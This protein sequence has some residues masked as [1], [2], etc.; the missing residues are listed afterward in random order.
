MCTPRGNGDGPCN[1]E[2]RPG[3]SSMFLP[4]VWPG[5]SWCRHSWVVQ[6]MEDTIIFLSLSFHLSLPSLLP[7][8]FS[9]LPCL[10]F[11]L[12][13]NKSLKVFQVFNLNLIKILIVQLNNLNSWPFLN[14]SDHFQ[15]VILTVQLKTLVYMVFPV[16]VCISFQLCTQIFNAYFLKSKPLRM[17]MN[18]QFLSDLIPPCSYALVKL[19]NG[20]PEALG[21]L[22]YFLWK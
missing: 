19:T 14:N 17:T 3:L 2:G 4:S 12:F 8:F 1:P 9:S 21:S 5:S 7:P 20:S 15:I 10:W 6:Q 13:F 18:S 11:F 16:V 22:F